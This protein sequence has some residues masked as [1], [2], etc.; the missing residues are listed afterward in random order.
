MNKYIILLYYNI[1]NLNLSI[2]NDIYLDETTE[3][4]FV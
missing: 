4:D 2:L 3:V 1:V